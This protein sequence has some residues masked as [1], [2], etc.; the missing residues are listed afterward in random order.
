MRL[1]ILKINPSGASGWGS[2]ELVFGDDITQ[3]YGPNGCGKTPV[4]HSIAY[5]MG[6][7]VRYREDIMDRCESV[8]LKVEHSGIEISFKRKLDPN[9]H[10]ICKLSNVD[11]EKHFYNEK[12]LSIFLLNYLGISTSALTSTKNEPAVPYISTF[13]PLFYVDQDSGYTSAYKAPS[14][15]V[16][17]QYS[18]M[19]RL[20]LGIPAKNSYEKKKHLIEKKGK[21]DAANVSI[22]NSERFI[23]K[24]VGQAGESVKDLA[25]IERQLDQ[26]MLQ[27]DELRS[28]QDA[29]GS[30]ESIL[31][32]MINEKLGERREIGLRVRNIESRINDFNKIKNEIEVEINTLSLNEESRRVF[33]SFSDICSNAGCQL[34]LS[35]SESYG[36]N[37]L[38]LRDQIKDLDRN[39][40][41]Q[42]IR[43]DELKDRF[44]SINEEIDRLRSSAEGNNGSGE[45]QGLVNTISEI[46]RTIIDL[47]REREIVDRIEKEKELY[48]ELLNDREELQNDIASIEGSQGGGDLRILE[49]RTKFKGKLADW[50]DVLSTKNVSRDISIDA[51]FNILFGNEKLSQFSGSTLLRAVLAI[52][53]AF[54]EIML[55]KESSQIEFLIFDTPRQHDIESEHFANFIGKLKDLVKGSSAQVIFSTTEY[56]YENQPNDIEWTPKFPGLEQ[57]MM[58][59]TV[60]QIN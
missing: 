32:S 51:D 22:V 24:L 42:E 11:E 35:S 12:E 6:Y 21:L 37:L 46:T 18:E 13:L 47:Q 34:F 53:S 20:S 16:K 30:S 41:Y 57:N 39:T 1:L 55:E 33:S 52:K 2:E 4:I 44:A 49:F 8:L 28:N 50:L 14:T 43:L 54:F 26:L 60:D 40:K 9:F 56:H 25:D 36:K 5:A 27:L 19:M 48:V 7:P 23:E 38:Y 3:L 45:A 31:N 29:V 10:V 17:D 59:G 15:F 58:L